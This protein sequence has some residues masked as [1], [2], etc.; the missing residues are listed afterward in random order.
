VPF[1]S[2]GIVGGIL[3]AVFEVACFYTGKTVLSVMSFGRM[4]TQ[5]RPGPW[6]NPFSRLPDRRIAVSSSGT[7]VLG[8][9]VWIFVLIV[10]LVL[11][12]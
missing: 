2:S 12:R 11:L 9:L 10:V 8:L 6:W 5:D 4:I 1:N 7:S 3:Q